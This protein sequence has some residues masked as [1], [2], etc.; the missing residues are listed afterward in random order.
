MPR[1]MDGELVDKYTSLKD[2]H[3][4]KKHTSVFR[5]MT[6]R[7]EHAVSSTPL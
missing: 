3:L 5:V 6:L 2:V 4:E 7:P 1:K